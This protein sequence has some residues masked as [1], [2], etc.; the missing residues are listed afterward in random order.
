MI[1]SF[2][3]S[4]ATP[5]PPNRFALDVAQTQELPWDLTEKVS[6]IEVSDNLY[7]I[8]VGDV[9]G[10]GE[11]NLASS[12]SVSYTGP[13]A[14]GYV[15]LRRYRTLVNTVPDPA[16]AITQFDPTTVQ[17]YPA[18]SVTTNDRTAFRP[19]LWWPESRWASTTLPAR[20]TRGTTTT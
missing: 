12:A 7:P 14:G 1:T 20:Q 2:T 17:E 3:D 16:L 8:K 19:S 10:S 15:A 9:P 13:D 4:N 18:A 6:L 5:L 11:L